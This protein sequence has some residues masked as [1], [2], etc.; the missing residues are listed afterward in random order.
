M[1]RTTWGAWANAEKKN[2]N[3]N[4]VSSVQETKQPK[5]WIFS[6]SLQMLPPQMMHRANAGADQDASAVGQMFGIRSDCTERGG[7]TWWICDGGLTCWGGNHQD[8][9]GGP[10]RW[11]YLL[12]TQAGIGSSNPWREEQVQKMDGWPEMKVESQ[13]EEA[14]MFSTGVCRE[15]GWH[16]LIMSHE[17]HQWLS[18]PVP[19]TSHLCFHVVTFDPCTSDSNLYGGGD[20]KPQTPPPASD[21]LF[22]KRLE[23]YQEVFTFQQQL[24]VK[25]PFNIAILSEHWHGGG[26]VM[27]WGWECLPSDPF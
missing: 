13:S 1:D 4:K 25:T 10:N 27:V 6:F 7:W 9:S 17:W 20:L 12:P 15:H 11:S 16:H 21:S 3:T 14:L 5:V 19:H 8:C 18:C 26:S 22:Q 2:H 24:E 23:I